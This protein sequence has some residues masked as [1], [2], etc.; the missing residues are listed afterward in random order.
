MDGAQHTATRVGKSQLGFKKKKERWEA[1]HAHNISK[2]RT[3][4]PYEIHAGHYMEKR[5]FFF[6]HHHDSIFLLLLI[7]KKKKKLF[8]LT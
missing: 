5:A 4:R 1:K 8:L 7:Q 2:R 6:H 3:S